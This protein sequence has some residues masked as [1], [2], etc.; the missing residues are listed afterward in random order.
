MST[1]YTQQLTCPDCQAPIAA[2]LARGIHAERR[3]DLRDEV[4]ARRFHRRTCSACGLQLEIERPIV[5]TDLDL[6]QW[7]YVA[8]ESDR[9]H[10]RSWEARLAA[11]IARLFSEH[12]PLVHGIDDQLRWRTVFGYEE[13]REKLVIWRAGLDDAI[14]ECLKVRAVAT[15]P[16]L[17]TPGSRLV[18]ERVDPG[19][20]LELVWFAAG[21]TTPTRSTTLPA[22]WLLDADRD[23]S[24]VMLRFPELFRGGYVNLRRLLDAGPSES[25]SRKISC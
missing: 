3:T 15:E 2:W 6:H 25:E 16:A 4:L 5:Y 13:L 18:V 17:G 10:W 9:R 23:R 12:S 21:A 24:S 8:P 19:D 14:V 20:R 7:V 11:D 22:A 1:F